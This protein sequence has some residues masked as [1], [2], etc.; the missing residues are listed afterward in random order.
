MNFLTQILTGGIVGPILDLI[1]GAQ[2]SR[3]RKTEIEAAAHDRVI[4][5]IAK[6]EEMDQALALAQVQ[7]AGWRDDWFTYL[8]SIPLVLA[9]VP[10][11]VPYIQ[12][13]FLALDGMPLFYKA[14]LGSAVA[15]AFGLRTVDKAWTWWHS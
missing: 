11:M 5:Q 10:K 7:S 12:Q 3:Q 13:G 9:F 1:K 6:T 4:E 14:F 2:E 15:S 8:L